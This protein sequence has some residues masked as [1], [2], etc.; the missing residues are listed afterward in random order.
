MNLRLVA[1]ISVTLLAGCSFK[2][3]WKDTTNQ[4]RTQE[5]AQADARVCS[6]ASGLATLNRDSARADF[7]AYKTKTAACMADRGWLL[8]RAE[9]QIKASTY[10]RQ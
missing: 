7:E 5:Q 3:E 2:T 9:I 1:I 10:L 4:G 6:D 8:V